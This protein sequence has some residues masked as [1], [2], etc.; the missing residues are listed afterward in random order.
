MSTTTLS[1]WN[2]TKMGLLN[3]PGLWFILVMPRTEKNIP[4]NILAE[5]KPRN[6]FQVAGLYAV[7]A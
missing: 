4:I 1:L 3:R 7:V 6:V 5:L 2:A